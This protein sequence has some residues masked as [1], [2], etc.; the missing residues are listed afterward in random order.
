MKKASF[1]LLLIIM[2]VGCEKTDKICGC[3]NPLEDISWLKE[4]KD[5]MTNCSCET[6]IFQATYKNEPVF[7]QSVT[8]PLCN[9]VFNVSIINCQGYV[10][11]TYNSG[12]GLFLSELSNKKII[13]TCK[14]N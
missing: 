13:Y 9:S 4:L 11:K 7:Y 12:D 5:S 3:N 2:S 6:S 1:L 8:D 10:L 14:A